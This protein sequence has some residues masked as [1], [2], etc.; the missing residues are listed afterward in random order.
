[1]AGKVL[2]INISDVRGIV[3]TSIPEVKVLENWGLEGD[4]HAG[5][6][7]RQVSIFPE[8]ALVKVPEH[9]R[10]EVITAGYTEN[11]TISGIA[12]DDLMAGTTIKIGEAEIHIVKVGKEHKE[13]G[14]PYIVSREGRFGKAVKGGKVKIGDEVTVI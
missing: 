13:H 10:K 1:M 12:L 7:D 9:K 5:D 14:R 11:F 8:E 3:K 2:A 4:A 6:W